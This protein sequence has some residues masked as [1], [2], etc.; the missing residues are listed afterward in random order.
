MSIQ[1]TTL[2]NGL[3]IAT[4]TMPD[5]ESVVVGAWVGV[6]TRHEPWSANGVAH[7][8]EHMMFKGT[9]TR[10][11]YALSS[12]IENKGGSM[13]AYTT[14]EET[15][16]YARVLP[17]EAENATDVI[18]DML[19]RSVFDNKELDR[20][21]QVI[22][23][24]I[25]RDLDSPDVYVDDLM[26]K[27]A[28][29]KQKMGRPILGTVNVIERLPRKMVS[30]YVA[31]HYVA[32]NTVLVAT[33]K[34]SHAEF[35]SMVKKRFSSLVPGKKPLQE[36]ARVSGGATLLEKEIEQ[37][38]IILGFAG[39]GYHTKSTY[40]TQLLSL[41]LGGT[42]SSR[43]F[44]KVREKRGLVY[45]VSSS[46]SGFSDTGIFQIY[47]GTDPKRLRELIPV[48][49]DELRDVQ[50]NV[51]RGELE[52]AKAQIRADMLM[53][54]ESV[55]R[56]AEV[57]GHQILAFGKPVPT[58]FI[59]KRLLAVTQEDVQVMASKIFTRKP[60]LT[61][62]GPLAEMENYRAIADRLAA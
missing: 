36:K 18:A 8:V 54:K 9:K 25:G 27:S 48:V 41:I 20:E 33:G 30:T 26:H 34:I 7:L 2:E 17:E 62:L 37:T 35:V 11:A 4:D 32:T 10:S 24:E 13:N 29:P 21:R 56:R 42:S 47:A 15:A 38:H 49:C 5:A 23:Q 12:E 31:K 57:L 59:L 14:R 55:M 22:I 45:T 46:H 1:I 50:H 43:L 61:A 3:R 39:P 19:R 52:R 58:D 60:I 40:S 28:L 44:Q 16:Y 51:T 6:G 53:G